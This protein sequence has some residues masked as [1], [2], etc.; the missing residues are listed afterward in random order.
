MSVCS[1]CVCCCRPRAAR[2]ASPCCST[3]PSPLQQLNLPV[4]E[5]PRTPAELA[6]DNAYAKEH[7]RRLMSAHKERQSQEHAFLQSRWTALNALPRTLRKAALVED[8]AQWPAG[9]QP[10]PWT[11]VEYATRFG[12]SGGAVPEAELHEVLAKAGIAPKQ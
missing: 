9:W 10:I 7:S 6:L 3:P 1:R 11:P 5:D 2:C 8:H 4:E 12:N